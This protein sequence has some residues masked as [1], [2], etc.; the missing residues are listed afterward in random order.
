MDMAGHSKWS[1]KTSKSY[2]RYSKR[3]KGV[4][5]KLIKEDTNTCPIGC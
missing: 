4:F 1:N 2:K 5:T 3:E